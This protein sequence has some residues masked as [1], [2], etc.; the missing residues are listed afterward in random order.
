[1]LAQIYGVQALPAFFLI[2]KEGKF[3]LKQT[4]MPSQ[5]YFMV[6]ELDKV[7]TDK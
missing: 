3:V 4:P 7:L 6:R 1:L 5:A 2:D